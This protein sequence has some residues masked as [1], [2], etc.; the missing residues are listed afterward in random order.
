[1][2]AFPV[3]VVDR[4]TS[5]DVPVAVVEIGPFGDGKV[6]E[7]LQEKLIRKLEYWG[8]KNNDRS[9]DL[10]IVIQSSYLGLTGF[11]MQQGWEGQW[12]SESTILLRT[13]IT[14]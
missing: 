6:R 5:P 14:R 12:V 10:G 2:G 3:K 4:G 1:L 9:Q 7:N 11:P 8:M 13:K